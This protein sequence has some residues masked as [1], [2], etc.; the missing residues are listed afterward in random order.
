MT[1]VVGRDLRPYCADIFH[2]IQVMDGLI[3]AD[4]GI[5]SFGIDIAFIAGLG[6]AVDV[7][8]GGGAAGTDTLVVD[9][10]ED[11]GP[12]SSGG[13]QVKKKEF[14]LQAPILGKIIGVFISHG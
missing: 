11:I 13:T 10:A 2:G 1:D 12:P 3:P 7:I 8:D 5:G 9:I 6:Q 14:H 4:I